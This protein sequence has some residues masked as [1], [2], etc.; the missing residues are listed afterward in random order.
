MLSRSFP[1]AAIAS[2]AFLA[3]STGPEPTPVNDDQLRSGEETARQVGEA[4]REHRED[5][6]R[7]IYAT[8][9]HA[10]GEDPLEDTSETRSA[11][12]HLDADG[13]LVDGAG[14]RLDL[15]ELDEL[16]PDSLEGR[17][18]R[19]VIDPD[20]ADQPLRELMPLFERLQ[21]HGAFTEVTTGDAPETQT[22]NGDAEQ[23]DDEPPPEDRE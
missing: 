8:S 13:R 4:A 18:V 14:E 7:A 3:C 23:S 12:V 6:G 22:G 20:A 21:D 16:S 9:R 15:D 1:V 2:L 10:T 11:T 5:D 17:V 19:I